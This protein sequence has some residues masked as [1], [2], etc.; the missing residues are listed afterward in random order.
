MKQVTLIAECANLL[1]S[2]SVASGQPQHPWDFV[3]S[4]KN[5]IKN[6]GDF[7][8]CDLLE[9]VYHKVRTHFI[10]QSSIIVTEKL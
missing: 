9:H 10:R 1:L 8:K 7:E 4:A 6:G 2:A 5:S 3:L